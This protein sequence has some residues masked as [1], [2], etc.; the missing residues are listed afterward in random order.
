MHYPQSLL[1]API[2]VLRNEERDTICSGA[3]HKGIL[4]TDHTEEGKLKPNVGLHDPTINGVITQ[5]L[6]KLAE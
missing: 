4:L 5:H 2:T 3:A 1:S 6:Q